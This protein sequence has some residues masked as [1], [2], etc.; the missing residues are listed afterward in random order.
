MT[1][2]AIAPVAASIAILMA[3]AAW[4]PLP[5]QSQFHNRRQGDLTLTLECL[6]STHVT[7]SIRNLGEGD[8]AVRLGTVVGNGRKYMIGDLQLRQKTT[9]GRMSEHRYEPRRYPVAIGGSLGEWIHAIPARSSFT[10]SAEADD[11][12]VG[13]SGRVTSFAAG[14]ELSLRLTI[15]DPRPEA[16]L[17]ASWSGTLTSNSCTPLE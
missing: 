17:L 1:N 16:M 10:M 3:L 7:F 12:W 11:F 9:A 6:D 8:T 5:A 13:A 14:A 2:K 15:L 4:S